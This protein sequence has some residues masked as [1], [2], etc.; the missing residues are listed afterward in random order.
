MSTTNLVLTIVLAVWLVTLGRS[1]VVMLCGKKLFKKAGMSEKTA[2]LPIINL[3]S[4]L[5]IADASSFWGILFFV[6]GFNILVLSLMSFKLGGVFNTSL[7]FKIGLVICPLLFYLLL[8]S[9][10]KQY[11][12]S[13]EEYFRGLDNST[14]QKLVL[15]D[16]PVDESPSEQVQEQ[17]L[18]VENETP[19]EERKTTFIN[20]EFIKDE[21]V[22]S[23][24]KSGPS[25]IE[26]S[27]PYK[28]AK[29]DLLGMEKLEELDLG[30]S[31][32]I[33]K[34]DESKLLTDDD[35]KKPEEKHEDMEIVDL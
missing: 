16:K 10:D 15:P 19:V 33:Q 20:E 9:S 31:S 28:A 27:A 6:P 2:L 26:K 7:G 8:A 12:L 13:D 22:D 30:E 25:T 35:F 29:I 34:I 21:P 11:K 17:S 3:F 5:E 32:N 14:T 1:I 23:I 24:F 4:V 18:M